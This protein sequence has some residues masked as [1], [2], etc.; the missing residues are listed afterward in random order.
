M[1]FLNHEIALYE[2]SINCEKI[3]QSMENLNKFEKVN[4]RPHLTFFMDYEESVNDPKDLK[5]I[6]QVIQNDLFPVF[7]AYLAGQGITKYKHRPRYI[8]S[9]MMPGSDMDSHR[10]PIKS[11][12]YDV[13]LNDNFSGGIL[14]FD[15][16]G[17]EVKPKPGT[18]IMFRP[19]ELH[20]VNMLHGNPRYSYGSGIER[21]D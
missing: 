16:L 11:Y 21:I 2:S 13:Y 1:E 15:E 10:D 19:Y 4:F 8:V 17:L 20:H 5:Y 18:L 12:A 14:I 7:D 3:I 9:K 6:R